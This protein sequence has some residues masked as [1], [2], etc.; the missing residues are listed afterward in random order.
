MIQ[1]L[2]FIE[3]QIDSTTRLIKE[4]HD[5]R[6]KLKCEASD[7][8]FKMILEK[9]GM[10]VGDVI[11][12]INDDD[13]YQI[14]HADHSIFS[15]CRAKKLLKDGSVGKRVYWLANSEILSAVVVG[16]MPVDEDDNFEEV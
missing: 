8:R 10:K 6:H 11:T 16:H 12:L 4:L 7:I 5:K 14:L 9:K 1:R 3:S 15:G 2:K 13:K